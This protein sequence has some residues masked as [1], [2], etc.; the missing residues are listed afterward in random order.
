[1][2]DV[3]GN[4]PDRLRSDPLAAMASDSD[5]LV[6]A[7]TVTARAALP[8]EKKQAAALLLGAVLGYLRDWCPPHQRTMGNLTLLLRAAV[9]KDGESALADRFYEM[10]TGC[11]RV[12]T[13]DG[14][15]SL[16][17]SAL[18]RLD[19]LSPKDENGLAPDADFSLTQYERYRRSG[20]KDSAGIVAALLAALSETE[21][22]G[23]DR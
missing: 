9:L 4:L 18:L 13:P 12:R 8:D 23:H 5:I 1:M 21:R 11:K 22:N 20:I 3:K 10:R 16:A 6:I 19:G 14:K 2:V 15:V 7:E 17:P